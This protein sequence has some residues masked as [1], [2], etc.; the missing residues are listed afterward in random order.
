MSVVRAKVN[1]YQRLSKS[2]VAC[3]IILKED[4]CIMSCHCTCMAGLGASCSH[5]AA[6]MFYIEAAVRLKEK[7]TVTLWSCGRA[8]KAPFS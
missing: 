6:T 1:H 3:W 2:P 4:G 8:V 7:K 5:A